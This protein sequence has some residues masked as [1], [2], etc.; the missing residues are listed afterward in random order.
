MVTFNVGKHLNAFFLI[1]WNI[2]PSVV[3]KSSYVSHR[4]WMKSIS[5]K[6]LTP[7]QSQ[8]R[9]FRS[10]L[11]SEGLKTGS[12]LDFK[13]YLM[14]IHH[15]SKCGMLPDPSPLQTVC[16]GP[17]W[18]CYG[19]RR[20]KIIWVEGHRNICFRKGKLGTFFWHG[21]LRTLFIMGF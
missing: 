16:E 7:R 18:I 11:G 17:H 5:K 13:S 12:P 9:K 20:G 1:S 3:P 21:F 14:F 19:Y 2:F 4:L 6:T 15:S 8:Y 10:S